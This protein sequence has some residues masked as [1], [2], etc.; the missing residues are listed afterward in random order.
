MVLV[1]TRSLMVGTPSNDSPTIYEGV[2]RVA[3][4]HISDLQELPQGKS[5]GTNGPVTQ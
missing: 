3:L 4:L 1:G 2:S 5:S